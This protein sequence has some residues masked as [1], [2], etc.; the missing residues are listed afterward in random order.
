MASVI[1]PCPLIPFHCLFVQ[2]VMSSPGSPCIV[3][4]KKVWYRGRRM[5]S[6]IAHRKVC[7]MSETSLNSISLPPCLYIVTELQKKTL[8]LPSFVHCQSTR[9]RVKGYTS[10]RLC[11]TSEFAKKDVDSVWRK[12]MSLVNEWGEM[13][14]E[15]L[16]MSETSLYFFPPHFFHLQCWPRHITPGR[17]GRE[18][19]LSLFFSGGTFLNCLVVS[20]CGKGK[21]SF[22]FFL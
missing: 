11:W 9:L 7:E 18:S 5:S 8:F 13:V 20:V 22:F 16:K 21:G 10:C 17:R 1:P 15:W 4:K 2:Q 3:C 6:I 14:W 12:D 19:P